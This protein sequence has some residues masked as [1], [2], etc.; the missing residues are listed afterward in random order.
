MLSNVWG[1]ATTL[2]LLGFA[3]QW[4]RTFPGGIHFPFPGPA[5]GTGAAGQDLAQAAGAG[6]LLAHGQ[7]H[8]GERWALPPKGLIPGVFPA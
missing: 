3:L 8:P 6:A 7:A 2:S 5:G 1:E 4:A